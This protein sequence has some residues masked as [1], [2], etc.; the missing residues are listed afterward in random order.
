LSS[1]L[2]AAH[3]AIEEITHRAPYPEVEVAT[4]RLYALAVAAE[5]DR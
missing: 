1:A 3:F 2:R 5:A 4:D